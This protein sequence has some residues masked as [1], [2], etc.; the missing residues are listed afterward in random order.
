LTVFSPFFFLFR[1]RFIFALLSQRTHQPRFTSTHAPEAVF[2]A[3]VRSPSSFF[4]PR[5]SIPG[6]ELFHFPLPPQQVRFPVPLFPSS[7]F[8]ASLQM[9]DPPR[10]CGW[11]AGKQIALF[12]DEVFRD[13]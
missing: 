8:S 4:A 5:T 7:I 11:L 9:L 10:Q 13:V 1:L 12:G 2:L 3:G 6:G